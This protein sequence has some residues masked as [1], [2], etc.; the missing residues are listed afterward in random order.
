M[1]L[2]YTVKEVSELSR[3]TVKTLHHYHK[4]GLL[5]PGEVSDAGYRL[6][7]TKELERLQE[8]LFYKEL[9]FP[10]DRIKEMMEQRS[11]RL[12]LL[13]R[14]EELLLGRRKRLDRIVETLR[15]S[16]SSEE[17]GENMDPAG[18]FKGFDDE[19]KWNEA[20]TEQNRHLKET[21]G[22]EPMEVAPEAVQGLNEQAVEAAA[23]MSGMASSL[24]EGVKH[25]DGK[26]GQ[27]IRDHL[28][29]MN[30]HGNP[31][32]AA[33]FA[34][35]NRFFLGDDFHLKML[36]SQQTGLAYYLAAAADSYAAT[37]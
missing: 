3:V 10:L 14:Q 28:A 34:S 19:E 2:L 1:T 8:I 33:D 16:I 21:Y 13:T 23:F 26:V 36:E 12:A 24:R 7:G 32:T 17:E 20:L 22:M 30:R 4:I 25:S 6:Y 11:D 18:M 9:E 35:Q 15:L 5:L 29:F 27:L 31:V 37:E